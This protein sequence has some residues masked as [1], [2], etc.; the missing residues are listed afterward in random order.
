MGVLFLLIGLLEKQAKFP[1]EVG[2]DEE[3]ITTNAIPNRF[4]A[5]TEVT[6]VVLKGGLLTFDFKN[7]KL[8]QKEIQDRVTLTLEEE[9]NAFC[10][11]QLEQVSSQ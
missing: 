8:Y 2:F 11:K 6:N 7:N 5:W 10:R 3:G 1:Q 4:Y 9:F